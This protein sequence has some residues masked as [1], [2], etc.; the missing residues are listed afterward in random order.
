M[1]KSTRNLFELECKL[2]IVT[3]GAQGF[4]VISEIANS[5]NPVDTTKQLIAKFSSRV[6]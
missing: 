1:K 4:A 6:K 2:A 5:P 3:G